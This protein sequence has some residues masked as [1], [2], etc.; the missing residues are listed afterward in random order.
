M[1]PASRRCRARSDE[2]L[3]HSVAR[4]QRGRDGRARTGSPVRA[5]PLLHLGRS[6]VRQVAAGS[7]VRRRAVGAGFGR[8]GAQVGVRVQCREPRRAV[9]T[10]AQV[11]YDRDPPLPPPERLGSTPA[12]AAAPAA[13]L[14]GGDAAT[15]SS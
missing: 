2:L 3:E 9:G 14:T 4:D 5:Q 13:T 10:G 7:R 8:L 11:A 15:G 6:V 12:E 1:T